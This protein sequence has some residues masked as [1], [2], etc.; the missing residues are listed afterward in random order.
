MSKP[1]AVIF[2]MDGSLCDVTSI[3]HHVI[4]KPKNFD[5]FHYGSSF[6]PPIEWV[7]EEARRQYFDH[8]R[9]VLIVTARE[10]RWSELTVNWL[11]THSIPFTEMF[12]RPT[13]DFRLDRIIKAELFA[14]I[15][16]HYDVVHAWD[17]NPA[18]I[19]LWAELGV[20]HT[21]VPGW[22]G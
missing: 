21:V 14:E 17:D 1:Q 5:A 11:D 6:C 15:S 2:D 7:A 8:K 18:I 3:R 12:M 16:Q 13:G 9:N 22:A 10:W 20:P 19:E 4:E